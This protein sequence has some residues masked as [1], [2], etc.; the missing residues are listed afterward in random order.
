M[1]AVR[2]ITDILGL[3]D[4][5]EQPVR[6]PPQAAPP[7][8]IPVGREREDDPLP[9]PLRLLDM[10]PTAPLNFAVDRLFV[11][12]EVNGVVGDGDAG[13]SSLLIAC[14]GAI[15][16]GE[17]ALRELRPCKLPDGARERRERG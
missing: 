9:G 1:A 7:S 14:A 12:D 15:A 10:P 6:P 4:M 17:A 8:G 3:I 11:A 5:T 16:A 2:Q 13:K